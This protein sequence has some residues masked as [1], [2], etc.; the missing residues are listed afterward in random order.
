MAR[1]TEL[2]ARLAADRRG[3]LGESAL[4]LLMRLEDT[5]LALGAVKHLQRAG[6]SLQVLD[7]KGRSVLSHACTHG[8]PELVRDLLRRGASHS[9]DEDGFTPLHDACAGAPVLLDP[10]VRQ[11]ICGSTSG[12]SYS[13]EDRWKGTMRRH[14]R[15]ENEREVEHDDE[16]SDSGEDDD[17]GGG[18]LSLAAQERIALQLLDSS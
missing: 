7:G 18:G 15:E 10:P 16:D 5:R 9:A 3:K 12:H 1:S 4:H 11:C 13:C 14:E 6:A 17:G 8:R 2:G